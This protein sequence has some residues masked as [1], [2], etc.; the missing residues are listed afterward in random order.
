MGYFALGRRLT[1]PVP[2]VMIACCLLAGC[3]RREAPA[4]ASRPHA[5]ETWHAVFVRGA[6]LGYLHTIDQ[7]IAPEGVKRW[8]QTSD[9]HIGAIRYGD[10]SQM[11]AETVSWLDEHGQLVAFDSRLQLGGSP[12][13][14]SGRVVA[15]ELVL[16]TGNGAQRRTSTIAWRKDYGGFDAVQQSLRMRPMQPG[17]IRRVVSLE[18]IIFQVG[19]Q[20]LTARQLESTPLLEGPRE[21]LRIDCV[22]HLPEAQP[23]PSVLWTDAAGEILKLHT[24]GVEQLAYRT[25]RE[26]ALAASS[27]PQLDLGTSTLIR[28]NAP[29]EH[30]HS[31][32]LVR[33]RV[34]LADGNPADVIPAGI[35][36]SVRSLGP[37][38]AEVTVRSV[39]PAA[40]TFGPAPQARSDAPPAP[41]DSQPSELV[42]SDDPL[43]KSL[44]REAAGNE[45]D[46][47]RTCTK[48]ERFVHERIRVKN[49]TQALSSAAETARRREGDC[50]E[51]AVLLAAMA[52][53][54]N[55]PARVAMGLV[56]VPSQALG[57]HM[58][59]EVFVGDEWVP[60]DAT[61][62]QGGIGAAHLKLAQSSLSGP[63]ALAGFLPLAQ[64]LGRLKVE[65]LSYQ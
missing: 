60:L 56:Y 41:A 34:E 64:V 65:V 19:R 39:V 9:L 1:W 32:K 42:E 17:E 51:H 26:R 28:L 40:A 29:I 10:P 38:V 2:G 44:A 5:R 62:G 35:T 53:A 11:E 49:F 20:E 13:R 15:D 61:L 14:F 22:L 31:T 63:G 54:Q 24:P 43:V 8:Q 36:Q 23:I 4:P 50:T 18:P 6:Q 59:T 45:A 12:Q 30:P 7:P 3:G 16:E 58:W 21:L 27:S 55:I 52:R 25:T 33:Y 57:F 47:W 46:A 48:L 37:H